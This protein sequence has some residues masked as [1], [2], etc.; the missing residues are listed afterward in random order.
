MQ[1]SFAASPAKIQSGSWVVAA[2]AGAVLTPA[3]RRADKAS[4]GAIS[5][6]LKVS[7]FTGKSGQLLEVLAPTGLSASRILLV[8]LGKPAAL[9]EKGLE[10]VGAQIV[11]RLHTLGETVATFEVEG[12]KGSKVK[13][14]EIAAHLAFGARLRSYGF[15]KYRTQES[16][17]IQKALARNPRSGAG[18]GCRQTRLCRSWRGGGRHF[19]GPRPGQ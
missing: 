1:I 7:R 17:R 2:S 13:S 11:A 12:P 9:D 4:G 14:G 3:A 15:D 16:G 19:P 18:R 5:R 6:G 8:G 10:T